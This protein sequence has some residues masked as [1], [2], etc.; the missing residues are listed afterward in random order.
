MGARS[1]ADRERKAI[2]GSD[3]DRCGEGAEANADGDAGGHAEGE[4]EEGD[5]IE[6][7]PAA[8]AIIAPKAIE[9][10]K[11]RLRRAIER[12]SRAAVR[13]KASVPTD[14]DHGGRRRPA[15]PSDR[16]AFA[17]EERDAAGCRLGWRR[18]DEWQQARRCPGGAAYGFRRSRG[19][20]AGT[21]RSEEKIEH[22]ELPSG[23]GE[24]E[25]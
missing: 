23:G 18:C 5:K 8:A 9:A 20:G 2:I 22:G 11:R 7:A 16:M 24:S 19:G 12:R 4:E 1:A 17:I 15:R 14:R 25:V 10:A 13:A 21:R 3:P 6:P